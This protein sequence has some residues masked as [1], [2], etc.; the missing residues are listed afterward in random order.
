MQGSMH[1]GCEPEYTPRVRQLLRTRSRK[2]FFGVS[3]TVDM[4]SPERSSACSCRRDKGRAGRAGHLCRPNLV[5]VGS[6]KSQRHQIGYAKCGHHN[7]AFQEGR[8]TDRQAKACMPCSLTACS[9]PR[10]RVGTGISHRGRSKSA[11]VHGAARKGN[12]GAMSA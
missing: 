11:G 7:E 6:G 1:Q 9:P 8:W 4:G 3:G 2:L 5:G 10:T 12:D